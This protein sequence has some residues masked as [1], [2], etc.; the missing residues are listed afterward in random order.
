MLHSQL[1]T[2]EYICFIIEYPPN[3][4]SILRCLQL[5]V[6]L[7]L[8][9]SYLW[10]FEHHPFLDLGCFLL[11]WFGILETEL[12]LV[13]KISV[14]C[15]HYF[16]SDSHNLDCIAFWHWVY[17]GP[18]ASLRT[19][20]RSP[21]CSPFRTSPKIE[22]YVILMQAGA[23]SAT[24]FKYVSTKYFLLRITD[25]ESNS[26][27]DINSFGVLGRNPCVYFH[28]MG[29]VLLNRTRMRCRTSAAVMKSPHVYLFYLLLQL[30]LQL[31][32]DVILLLHCSL[33]LLATL[34]Q[35]RLRVSRLT[36]CNFQLFLH[37][38]HL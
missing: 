3:V 4:L 36:V 21:R 37:P 18:T 10:Q 32:D 29:E 27:T 20:Q 9:F 11:H 31:S 28:C 25:L 12:S 23:A 1:Q 6:N 26:T 33:Q 19:L 7:S 13:K 14:K 35:V 8:S 24:A 38:L 15:L 17:F 22:L 34:K 2:A 30:L 5:K 16:M